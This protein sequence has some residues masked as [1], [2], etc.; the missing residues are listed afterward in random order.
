MI[1]NKAPIEEFK[2]HDETPLENKSFG[3]DTEYNVSNIMKAR[4]PIHSKNS[5]RNLSE[6]IGS[7]K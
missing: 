4:R 3:D 7:L 5:L 6:T 2:E 1:N